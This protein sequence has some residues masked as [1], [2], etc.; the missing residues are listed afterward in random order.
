[1][2]EGLFT[3]PPLDQPLKT[4][5][6]LEAAGASAALT[7]LSPCPVSRDWVHEV[8]TDLEP[9]YGGSEFRF[10]TH[11]MQAWRFKREGCPRACNL[12]QVEPEFEE[13]RLPH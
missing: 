8:Q 4:P 3:R 9:P 12:G 13:L 2:A 1:M 10:D 11:L 7:C 6:T 5:T